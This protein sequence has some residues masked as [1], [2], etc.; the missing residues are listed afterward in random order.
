[1]IVTTSLDDLEAE[2]PELALILCCAKVLTTAE[3]EVSIRRILHEGIDWIGFVRRAVDHGVAALAGRSLVRI[4]PD[5]V[6]DDILDA[7]RAMLDQA[8]ARNNALF[9]ELAEVIAGL[10]ANGVEAIPFKGPVLALQSYGDLA[11]RMFRDLD[12]LIRDADID[13]TIATLRR[14]GYEP[15]RELTAAQYELIHRLQGQEIVF[16]QATGTAIEPHTRLTPIKMAL[17]IDYAALWSRARRV[18]LQGRTLLTLAP[19]DDLITLAIHGGKE[20]W[21]NIKWACD[22]AAFVGSHPNLDW[23]SVIERA[24]AQGCARMVL[25]AT[26]LVRQHFNLALPDPVVAAERA[27]PAMAKMVRRVTALWQAETPLG[28]ASNNRLSI[29]RLRLHDGIVRQARYVGRTLFLPGPH[30]VMSMPLPKGASFAY[31]PIKLAHDFIALPL[32]RTYRRGLAQAE[33]LQDALAGSD[34]G[35]AMMP[36]SAEMKSNIKRYRRARVDATREVSE[37]P[38]NGAAWQRLGDSLSGLKRYREAVVCYDKALALAPNNTSV[39]KKREGAAELGGQAAGLPYVQPDQQDANA[40]AVQAGRFFS[41]HRFA[42]ALDASDRALALHPGNV[43]AARIGIR[44]RLFACDWRKREADERQIAEG[45]KAGVHFTTPFFHRAMSDSEADSLSI[46]RIWAKG[47]PESV[48]PLWRGER[49]RHDKIRLAYLSTDFRDHVVADTI[50]GCFE[51]HDRTRFE[52][53]A[54]SLG[55]NDKSE[56]RRRLESVFDRFVDVEGASEVRIAS[57]LRELEIDIAI[58]LNGN[59]GEGRPEVLAHRPAPVQVNYL[60]YPGTMGAS[61][62]DYIIADPVVIPDGN[63]IHYAEHVAYLPHT[64]MPHDRARPIRARTPSRAAAGLPEKGFVFACHNAEYKIGPAVFE[65]WMRLLQAV[66]GSV[67]W[68]RSINSSAMSNLRREAKARGIAPERLVLAPRVR[69]SADHLARLRLA[70]LFLDTIPYNAHASACDALWAGLPVLTCMGNT[71]AARV[72]ASV[73]GAIGLPELVTTSLTEYETLARTL[74]LNPGRLDAIRAKLIRNRDTEP[75]FDTARFTRDLEAAYTIMWE[76]QQAGL[77][78]AS[79]SVAGESA[80]LL[81][82]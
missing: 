63:R 73:L 7:F 8:R 6:P 79:F 81:S 34:L 78:A 70:D 17:D 69:H 82:R 48:T 71:F 24:R 72:A 30:H 29:D 15:N 9:D 52:T 12:F 2:L 74:A 10:A 4:A 20:M 58:D 60:G 26:S 55:P 41:T 35:L 67:L 28:P 62:M 5:L 27:D 3:D 39:W 46:A 75:L 65:V 18:N 66:D 11:L 80:S 38:S 33:R 36:A 13:P 45:L 50:V 14:F 54:V 59:S 53:V 57:K 42:E 47:F 23:T 37:N 22:V 49:Y 25:L 44:S 16:K 1:V 19:E 40:W 31:I 64:Y 21:W 68:L 77:P 76:R 32:W 43:A 56:M 61:Y 51:H